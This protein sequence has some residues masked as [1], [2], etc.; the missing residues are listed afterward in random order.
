MLAAL[1]GLPLL[2]VRLVILCCTLHAVTVVMLVYVLSMLQG[3]PFH[4]LLT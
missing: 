1:G 3:L 4:V 2:Q